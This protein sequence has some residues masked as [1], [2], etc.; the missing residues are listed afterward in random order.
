MYIA[1]A[2]RELTAGLGGGAPSGVQG[3]GAKPLDRESGDKA[4]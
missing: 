3:P 2:E 4:P 1:S